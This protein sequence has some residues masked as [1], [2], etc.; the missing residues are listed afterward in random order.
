MLQLHTMVSTQP[1][2]SSVTTCPSWSG[3]LSDSHETI[4]SG[5]PP[6]TMTD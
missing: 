4:C 3:S 5:K 1:P 6:P 2:P